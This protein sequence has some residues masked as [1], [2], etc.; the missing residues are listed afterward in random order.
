MHMCTV[1]FVIIVLCVVVVDDSMSYWDDFYDL[2]YVL[3]IMK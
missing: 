2:F 3:Q 1:S